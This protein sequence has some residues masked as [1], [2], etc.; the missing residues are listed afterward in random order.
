M[1]DSVFP[2]NN[3]KARAIETSFGTFERYPIRTHVILRGEDLGQ[4]VRRYVPDVAVGDDY[5]FVSEKIVA[6]CQGRA[7]PVSEIQPSPLAKL[8]CRFVYRSPYGIGLGSPQT[9]QLAIEEVGL[10]RLLAAAACSALTKPFGVRGVFYQIA[11]TAARAID[12]PC[13][14]TIPPYNHYAKKAPL[15]PDRVARELA[16]LLGCRVV[17]IDANDLGVEVLGKSSERIPTQFCKQV[18]RDNPLGQ[19]RESTPL[20]VVRRAS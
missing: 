14:C 5:L 11:G 2:P 3:G 20:C 4:I 19:S 16:E 10:P 8:L 1:D 9:M 15:E 12:G 13:E 7:W 17:I 18:F 6:I